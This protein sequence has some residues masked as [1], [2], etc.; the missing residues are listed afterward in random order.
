MS[1]FLSP[2][3]I[4][5][6]Y[7]PIHTLLLEHHRNK[8]KRLLVYSHPTKKCGKYL[9]VVWGQGVRTTEIRFSHQASFSA[10]SLSLGCATHP[11]LWGRLGGKRGSSILNASELEDARGVQSRSWEQKGDSLRPAGSGAAAVL[12]SRG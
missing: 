10:Q 2:Q 8:N 9:C 6:K 12:L 7:G 1:K 4:L 5:H 11:H 3:K